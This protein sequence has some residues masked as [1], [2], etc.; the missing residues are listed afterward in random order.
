MITRPCRFGLRTLSLLTGLRIVAKVSVGPGWLAEGAGPPRAAPVAP[1]LRV[2]AHATPCRDRLHQ[3]VDA[4]V[5]G[6]PAASVRSGSRTGQ[7]ELRAE[8][9]RRELDE[10]SCQGRACH[11]SSVMRGE[12]ARSR[13][14]TST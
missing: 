4:L 8:Q 7:L 13:S 3:P 9:R 2:V 12:F 11:C 1:R 5:F 6:A 10:L 14:K